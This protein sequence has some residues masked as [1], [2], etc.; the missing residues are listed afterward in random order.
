MRIFLSLSTFLHFCASLFTATQF[1]RSSQ[2]GRSQK[3]GFWYRPIKYWVNMGDDRKLTFTTVP[4]PLPR[5]PIL[6]VTYLTQTS[7]IRFKIGPISH[8]SDQKTH[9]IYCS[10]EKSPFFLFEVRLADPTNMYI[11]CTM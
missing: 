10:I 7:E 6:W 9:K 2:Q 5:R 11:C 4:R 3:F 1:Y 8:N